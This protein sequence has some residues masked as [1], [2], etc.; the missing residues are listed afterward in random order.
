MNRPSLAWTDLLSR[1]D[2]LRVGSLGL[3][4]SLLPHPGLSTARAAG[5]DRPATARS[6]IILWMAGGVT[7]LDSFDPKPDAADT[8]RG[9][10]TAIRTTIPG[11]QIGRAHV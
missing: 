1:R 2:V 3:T 6:V 10:L 11:V 8:V 9:A 4:A 7:H 5:K